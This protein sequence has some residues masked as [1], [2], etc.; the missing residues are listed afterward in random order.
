MVI[1]YFINIK[2]DTFYHCKKSNSFINDLES[3]I[4]EYGEK[5]ISNIISKYYLD[6][7][8]EVI[9]KNN[10]LSILSTL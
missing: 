8:A 7:Y 9:I 4:S 10:A 2:T 6:E 1:I 5:H 3:I